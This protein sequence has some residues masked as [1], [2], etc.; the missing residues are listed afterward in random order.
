MIDTHAHLTDARFAEDVD[1]VIARAFA[2]GLTAMVTVATT[3][4]NSR[5]AIALAER[6]PHLYATVGIHPHYSSGY[7]ERCPPV[8]RQLAAHP[9]VVAIGETGL[10]YHYDNSPRDVQR[11][12]FARHLELGNELGLPVVVHSRE[13][14][15]DLIALLRE[16]PRGTRGVLHSYSSGPELLEAG[17]ELGWFVSF[18]GMVTF[19]KFNGAKLLRR[20]PLERLLV[21]TDSPYLSPA[22][23]RGQR[24]EPGNVPLVAQR[25]AELRG[26][27]PEEVVAATT[28]NARTLFALEE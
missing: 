23:H 13:A 19:A 17:L 20:V 24:N 22:P 8:I 9:R 14:D 25:V 18:S 15:E 11:T 2:G 3:V 4:D 16:A 26:E 7:D 12:S 28:R 6:H 10:D 1:E 5:E 27:D 21:E